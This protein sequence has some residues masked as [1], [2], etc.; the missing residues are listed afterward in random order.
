MVIYFIKLIIEQ[1]NYKKIVIAYCYFRTVKLFWLILLLLVLDYAHAQQKYEPN[2][3]FSKLVYTNDTLLI[4]SLSIVPNSFRLIYPELN[5]D[6]YSIDFIKSILI[7]NKKG[8]TKFDTILCSYKVLPYSLS[9]PFFHKDFKLIENPAPNYYNQ[10]SYNAEEQKTDFLFTDKLSKNGSIARGVN[11]GNNQDLVVNSQLNLQLNGRLNERINILAAIADDN[12]PIQPDGNTQQLQEFDKVFIQLYDDKT[13]LTVGDYTLPKPVTSYFSVYNKRSQGA[14]INNAFRL[15]SDTN[16][17]VAFSGAAAISRGKFNRYQLPIVE[18]NQGPYPL[19]GADNELFVIV[20]SG[21]ERVFMDGQLLKRGLEFDYVIDYNS[22]QIRFMPKRQIT[23]DRRVFVEFQYSDKN[24]AR[25]LVQFGNEYHS[26]NT[27]SFFNIYSEQDNKNKPLLQTLNERQQNILASIGDSL[28]NAV[29]YNIDTVEFN[30]TTILYENLDTAVG[31]VTYKKIFKY[32][33]NPEKARYRLSFSDVGVGRGNY[34][35]SQSA[36]NGK[37]YAWVAPINGVRQGRFEPVILLVT[38]KQKIMVNA[39]VEQILN[40]HNKIS[41]ETA[42]SKN[43][44]NTFSNLDSRNDIGFGLKTKWYNNNLLHANDT[45]KSVLKAN[46]NFELVDKNFTAIERF[47]TVEFDRDWNLEKHS[48]KN[49]QHISAVNLNLT[50]ASFGNI[51]YTINSFI[52]QNYYQGIRHN[53]SNNYFKNDLTINST[54]SYLDVKTTNNTSDFLRH[55]IIIKKNILKKVAIGASEEQERNRFT[56]IKDNLLS[57][58]TNFFEWQT[59]AATLDTNRTWIKGN[60]TNRKD[61]SVKNN[62]FVEVAK[63]ETWQAS[64]GYNSKNKQ[65]FKSTI[66]YRTLQI[67]DSTITIIKPENTLLTREEAT[68]QILK[69]LITT[70]SFYE[71]SSGLE[72]KKEY[73]FVEVAAGQGIYT[74]I[75][76]ND[77]NVK[78]LNEFEVAVF[79]DKAQYLRV[80]TPTNEFVKAY[81]NQ[82]NQVLTI[83]PAAYFNNSTSKFKKFLARFYNQSIYRIDRK[84]GRDFS[85]NILNPLSGNSNDSSL[86]TLSQQARN[87]FAFN[88]NNSVFAIEYTI[89]ENRNTSLLVNGKEERRLTQNTLK[90]RYAISTKFNLTAEG[91]SGIKE[92]KSEF[93]NNRNYKI[94]YIDIIPSIIFQPSVAFR[95][96]INYGYKIKKNLSPEIPATVLFNNIGAEA[97]YNVSGKSSLQAKFTLSIIKFDADVN[98]P[99]AFEMLESLQN[100]KNYVW[101]ISYQQSLSTNLQL[102]ITYDGRKS[103][104]SKMIHNGGVQLRAAF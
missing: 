29:D 23:K 38:P 102:S 70:N 34:I 59:F 20:L 99:I 43:D 7:F 71:F 61:W 1:Y 36:A 10:F 56:T 26:K 24:Y 49:L 63:A 9:K 52:E 30:A 44:V 5:S 69:G 53:F 86:V 73:S 37:V 54:A 40:P 72:T 39:G 89:I 33:I 82:L 88:R 94:N 57:S 60:Y 83:N 93:F 90:I 103:E 48:T 97:K 27:N 51:S 18:G 76:Y 64:F 79:K 62:S 8:S 35:L 31:F 68:F 11:F 16:K 74:W 84:T 25:S 28:N 65:Q 78:E 46:I 75:D 21:S 15:K 55:R 4:D 104:T 22:A 41:V 92:N 67:V 6:E 87:T 96:S 91:N 2:L 14:L 95:T 101:N 58:N 3:R 98:S 50:T 47:R 42:I 19:R 100:G 32:S 77:N 80:F 85:L 13:K 17:M 12:I 45:L 81:N 66:N